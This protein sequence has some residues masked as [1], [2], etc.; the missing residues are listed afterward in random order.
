ML[1]AATALGETDIPPIVTDGLAAYEKSSGKEAM[2]IWLKGS[3]VENDAATK[4][5]INGYIANIETS[6]GKMIGYE[7]ICVVPFTPSCRRV[8]V[9]VKHE[10]G[11]TYYAFDC[12]KAEQNWIIP[13]VEL[14][15]R[16]KEVLTSQMLSGTLQ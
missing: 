6:Y 9:L 11:P 3:A 12:Y 5:N 7:I 13:T 10:R 14:N 8:Y 16:P 4:G 1:F 15:T 2:A